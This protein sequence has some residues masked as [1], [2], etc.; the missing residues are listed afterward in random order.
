MRDRA[1]L[2]RILEELQSQPRVR[3]TTPRYGGTEHD[4]HDV[5]KAHLLAD[6]ALLEYIGDEKIT[7]A[8]EQIP[9]WY[10]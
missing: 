9:K 6:R 8:Y 10:S 3:F 2:L 1:A 4:D 7:A 5:E